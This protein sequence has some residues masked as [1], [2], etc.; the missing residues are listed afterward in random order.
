MARY[1]CW[2]SAIGDEIKKFVD[3]PDGY[4]YREMSGSGR[5]VVLL[6]GGTA[7]LRMWDSTVAWLAGIARVTTFDYRD[8]G[9]S[10][11]GTRPYD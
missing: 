1:G 7:D 4:L 6:N 2:S 8:T 5:D 9:L 3:M 11:A 10:S